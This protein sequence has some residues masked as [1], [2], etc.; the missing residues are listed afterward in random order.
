MVAWLM[1]GGGYS[2][3]RMP[4]FLQKHFPSCRFE[5][6]L[7]I[8][9]RSPLPYKAGEKGSLSGLG[10]TGKS[11]IPQLRERLQELLQRSDHRPDFLFILDDL[12]CRDHKL[13]QGAIETVLSEMN[14]DLDC[15]VGFAAPEVEAW[16]VADWDGT[17]G[18]CSKFKGH[19]VAMR[20]TLA[21]RGINFEHPEQFSSMDDSTG[22]CRDKLSQWLDD[23]H[24]QYFSKGHF[25]KKE[26]TP[27][28]LMCADPQII[29]RKAPLF[30]RFWQELTDRYQILLMDGSGKGFPLQ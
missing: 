21:T 17:F 19:H 29:A 4:L 14:C 24:L 8:R 26:D 22:S 30:C 15:I 2:E 1:A 18:R 13:A 25:S 7:P 12:D 11:F 28:L 20:Y 6:Q 5:R 10:R 27:E 16:L 3:L 9:Q 23:A